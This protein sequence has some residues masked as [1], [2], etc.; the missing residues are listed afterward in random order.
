MLNLYLSDFC[1]GSVEFILHVFAMNG[2]STEEETRGT[3]HNQICC[4]IDGSYRCGRPAGNASYSKRI[5]KTVQQRR[6]RL[7]RD[8]SVNHIYICDHHKNMIQNARMKRKRRDSDDGDGSLDADEDI[9]EIDFFQMPV[10]TLRRYKRHYKLPARPGMNK[11]Q[12]SDT[13]ARHFKSIP[14]VEKEAL[15]Y[16]IYMAKNF[17]KKCYN[18]SHWYVRGFDEWKFANQQILSSYFPVDHETRNYVRTVEDSIFSIVYPTPL[19]KNPV[20]AAVSE[21]VLM[22][23][24]G[25]EIDWNKETYS[26]D[27]MNFV[28]GNKVV[29][30]SKPLAHR[31]GGHQFGYWSGQLGD[32]RAVMLGEYVNHLGEKWELQLKGSGLTPYSRRGD[33]K[34]VIRSSVREFLCSEAMYSL[35]IPTSRAATLVVSD[36]P[37]IRDQ[38]YNGNIKQEKAAVVLRLAKSWF[39]IGSLEILSTNNEIFLLQKL[40]DFIIQNYFPHISL[41]DPNRYLMFYSEVVQQTAVM[42]A[43]WQSVGFTHGV[44]NTDNF[45]I[46]SITIDYGPFGF[47]DNYDTKFVP[48]TSDDE[49]RY[50]YENQPDVG[51]FNLEKLKIALKPL[52]TKKQQKQAN[53]ILKG[54]ADIYKYKYMEIYMRKL[55][56]TDF[57][58]LNEE[59]EQFLA[60]LLKIMEDTRADFTMTFR[61]L[62]EISMEILLKYANEDNVPDIYWNLK[63]LANHE[64]FSQW[65]QIYTQKLD[66][67]GIIDSKRQEI[68]LNTNPRYILRNWIAQSAIK[69]VENNKFDSVKFILKILQNPFKYNEEAEKKGFASPPP[70]WAKS[71]K[72]SCSS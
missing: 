2:F 62:S 30:G 39:R 12:L 46:L 45:S 51:R 49:G 42:I 67:D 25:L 9:P 4:L 32:G 61:E 64:W 27:F 55:G 69:D 3:G 21:D 56:F 14:V 54:Y 29:P 65:L 44:C 58:G 35:G 38:F 70:N 20:L 1:A 6:L 33:G 41:S 43:L 16:F 60:I 11:A 17:K 47:L 57:D 48:N 68:M 59:N 71:L 37:V 36:D 66:S 63:V 40:V 50:S 52:L 18:E 13:V 5:Q 26:N 10:N 23:I 31:Y 22:K 15:T 7:I 19:T 24:L 53:I 28:A 72:V 34:A 8:D